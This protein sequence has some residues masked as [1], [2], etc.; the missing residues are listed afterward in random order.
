MTEPGPYVTASALERLRECSGSIAL[1]NV[2]TT[3]EAAERGTAVHRF[4]E[5]MVLGVDRDEAL[6]YVPEEWRDTCAR[7]D[8]STVVGDLTLSRTPEVSYGVNVMNST[9]MSLGR[10]LARAYPAPT[11]GDVWGTTDVE[12]QRAWDQRWV[13]VDWKTGD[14][15]PLRENLQLQ[16]AARAVALIRG[17]PEV[18]ARIGFVRHSGRIDVE[19]HVFDAFE[20]A[21]FDEELGDLYARALTAF[22]AS[23]TA[24]AKLPPLTPGAHCKYCPSLPACPAQVAIARAMLPDLEVISGQLATMTPEDCGAAYLKLRRMK[25][26]IEVVDKALKTM[27]RAMP[28]PVDAES[29]VREISYGQRSFDRKGALH[30]LRELGATD[31]QL[32]EIEPVIMINRVDIYR[33][34]GAPKRKKKAS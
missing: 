29:E 17:V 16:F 3:S 8:V 12:G 10:N 11:L 34:P 9:A 31:E 4:A 2:L 26:L 23:S 32:D 18:E 25:A 22:R 5:R 21:A 30:L 15:T 1:P 7:M 27:A 20:L 13:I 19:R 14:A 33:R 24:M 6:T 28:L